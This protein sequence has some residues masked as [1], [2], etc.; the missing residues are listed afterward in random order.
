MIELSELV[1]HPFFWADTLVA[2]AAA[3]MLYVHL[4]WGYIAWISDF[5]KYSW[6]GRIA[7]IC[8]IL[9]AGYYLFIYN[10]LYGEAYSRW[11][12]MIF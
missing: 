10:S 3:F 8:G 6:Q 5:E 9:V 4:I 7:A 1:H 11:L 12:S 2:F